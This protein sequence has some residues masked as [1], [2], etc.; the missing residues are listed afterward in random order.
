MEEGWKIKLRWEIAT[1]LL[2]HKGKA[3]VDDLLLI[4]PS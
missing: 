4:S 3:A 1:G 2:F